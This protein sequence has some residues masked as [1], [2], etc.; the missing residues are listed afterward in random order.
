MFVSKTSGL[1]NKRTT[2]VNYA[3]SIFNKLEA[4]HTDDATVIIYDRHVLTVQ[5]TEPT[6]EV[7]HS[8]GLAHKQ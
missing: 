4:L 8:I 6:F 2:I 7:L 3:S 5:A 1:Y